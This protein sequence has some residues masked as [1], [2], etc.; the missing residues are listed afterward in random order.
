MEIIAEIPV[1]LQRGNVFHLNRSCLRSVVQVQVLES[2]MKLEPLSSF[3]RMSLCRTTN[4]SV[5]VIMM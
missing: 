4:E 2:G 5:S 3:K 1:L